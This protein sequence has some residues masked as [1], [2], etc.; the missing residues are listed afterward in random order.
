M[1]T[2]VVIEGFRFF[3]Y[4]NE[5][6]PTHVHVRHGSGEACFE[7]EPA[8]ELRD[9]KGMSVA[10]LRKALRLVQENK[11]LFLEKWNEFFG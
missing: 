9:S 1:P 10:E 11:Q 2:I 5:H 7:M 4:S 3:F 6:Q 8:V